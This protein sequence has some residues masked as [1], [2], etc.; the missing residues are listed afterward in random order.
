ML[1]E[2]KKV[3]KKLKGFLESHQRPETDMEKSP[4]EIKTVFLRP[5][6]LS[7]G[8]TDRESLHFN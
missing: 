3:I 6:R 8:T 7:I 2:K 5:F 1:K 4:R